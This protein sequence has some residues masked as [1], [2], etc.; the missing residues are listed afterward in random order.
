MTT[1][2]T[3]SAGRIDSAFLDGLAGRVQVA[4]PESRLAITNAMT[5][6]PLGDVPRCTGTDVAAAAARAR[7]MQPQWAAQPV[8]ARGDAAALPRI[9]AATPG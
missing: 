7:A 8:R 1:F 3:R 4:D 2:A 5:G 6:A 9:G